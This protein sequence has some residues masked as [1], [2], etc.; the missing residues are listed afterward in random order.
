MY[1]N[2]FGNADWGGSDWGG[3]C[4]IV[5]YAHFFILYKAEYETYNTR[6][7]DG[8]LS[9]SGDGGTG[10]SAELRIHDLLINIT[11]YMT[12]VPLTNPTT[13]KYVLHT[14]IVLL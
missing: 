11:G 7:V 8:E 5:V 3:N 6:T 1:L 4:E 9:T 13:T 2:Y 12:C 10:C 14:N